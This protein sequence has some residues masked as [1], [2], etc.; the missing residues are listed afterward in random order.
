[1][2]HLK[3]PRSWVIVSFLVGFALTM[4]GWVLFEKQTPQTQWYNRGMIAYNSGNYS[5]AME[6]FDRSVSEFNKQ[7]AEK[8]EGLLDAPPSLEMAQLAQCH[9]FLAL[10]KM[11]NGQ[12][13]IVAVKEGLKLSTDWNIS[14]YIEHYPL[15]NAERKKLDEDRNT[16]QTDLEILFHQQKD[17]ADGEGKGKGNKPGQQGQGDKQSENPS[18]GNQAGKSSRDAL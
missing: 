3:N 12:L 16:C 13:A 14:H 1:M 10:L 9:K 7:L 15:S 17:K 4:T 6:D 11:K 8:K 2:K 18:N 5:V